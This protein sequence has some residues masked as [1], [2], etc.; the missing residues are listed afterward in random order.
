MA[1]KKTTK[2]RGKRRLFISDASD[3]PSWFVGTIPSSLKN[4]TAGDWDALRDH[5]ACSVMWRIEDL[6][7]G[8]RESAELIFF[9]ER[10]SDKVVRE[11]PDA[12]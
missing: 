7:H 8:K 12:G 2:P 5:L 4:E 3:E 6:I 10:I 9:V 11:L 1:R